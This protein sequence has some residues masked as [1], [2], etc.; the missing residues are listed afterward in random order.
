MLPYMINHMIDGADVN[1]KR[2]TSNTTWP[3]FALPTSGA[4]AVEL[5]RHLGPSQVAPTPRGDGQPTE[6]VRFLGW[7]HQIE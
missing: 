5:R 6:M 1:F 2:Y 7:V 3:T 4:G